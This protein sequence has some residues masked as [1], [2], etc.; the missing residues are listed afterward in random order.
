[1]LLDLAAQ[2][3]MKLVAAECETQDTV[4]Y[5]GEVRGFDWT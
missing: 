2:W 3:V 4:M 5:E 1:M